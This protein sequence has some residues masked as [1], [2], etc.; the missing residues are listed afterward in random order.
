[1]DR[2]AFLT[3]DRWR[4]QMLILVS[5]WFLGRVMSGD[6][7]DATV[8]R[9]FGPYP[10]H[11]LCMQ[12]GDLMTDDQRFWTP[13]KRTER[14]RERKQQ[15]SAEHVALKRARETP[16]KAVHVEGQAFSIAVDRSGAVMY[17]GSLPHS[18]RS[19]AAETG[20]VT[21]P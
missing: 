17:T 18:W 5:F 16:G 1:M 19:V 8:V 11:A 14:E 21:A 12:A 7:R 3:L 20:C 10:S 9:A 6:V 4:S 15:S 2:R 13:E